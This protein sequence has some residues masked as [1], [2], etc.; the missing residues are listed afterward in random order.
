MR[1]GLP[2]WPHPT[3]A[4]F[5]SPAGGQWLRCP[6]VSFTVTGLARKLHP[7]PAGPPAPAHRCA[8]AC[9]IHFKTR[10]AATWLAAQKTARPAPR[11]GAWAPLALSHSIISTFHACQY[12]LRCLCC[13]NHCTPTEA[14]VPWRWIRHARFIPSAKRMLNAPQGGSARLLPTGRQTRGRIS[15]ENARRGREEH[16]EKP[17]KPGFFAN[18]GARLI[19]QAMP[20]AG[21]ARPPGIGFRRALPYRFQHIRTL[22]PGDSGFC[23]PAAPG[24]VRLQAALP[25]PPVLQ[26]TAR[27][28]PR[29]GPSAP[30][31]MAV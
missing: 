25:R 19:D 7:L 20:K 26:R 5:P 6:F 30:V 4:A 12:R 8:P 18:P 27:R 24:S 23:P 10:A 17:G 28:L 31:P 16:R 9:A 2:A 29:R 11:R 22:L 13:K 1:T 14:V 21:D 3:G 15:A